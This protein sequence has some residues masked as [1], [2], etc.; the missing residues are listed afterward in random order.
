M[1]G[2]LAQ[3]DSNF[4]CSCFVGDVA[5]QSS[6][7]ACTVL[8]ARHRG[9]QVLCLLGFA[10]LTILL[11]GA[12]VSAQTPNDWAW[13]G[14]SENAPCPDCGV[15]GVY[16]TQGTSSPANIPGGRS[17]AASWTDS[18]GNLWLFGGFGADANGTIGYLNDLWEYSTTAQ[19][20]TWIGG[21][22]TLG[23]NCTL[24]W[25]GVISC[26]QSGVYGEKN[27]AA[28]GNSPGGR[29]LPVTWTDGNG[30]LWLF[31]GLGF[32]STGTSGLLNDL[33]MFNP[34]TDEWTWVSGS[35]V[36]GASGGQAGT[37]GTLGVQGLNN[38]PGGRLGT[39][40]W[41]DLKGNLWLFGGFGYSAATG[42][43]S[44][45]LNDL[46]EFNPSTLEWTWISGSNA[47][48]QSGAY[49]TLGSAGVGNVPGARYQ[50]VSWR[51][52]SGNLWMF[53][54]NGV[55]AN[56]TV[57]F[58][59][60]LWVFDIAASVWTWT[61]GNNIVNQGPLA[62]GLQDDGPLFTPGSRSA[63]AG[64]VDLDNNL[65]VMGG[66]GYINGPNGP[67]FGSL[68]DLWT[69]D[70]GGCPC[71]PQYP[72]YEWDYMSG[73]LYWQDSGPVAASGVYG[74][75]GVAAAANTPGGRQ[76]A[77]SWT[78]NKGNFWMFGG[79]GYGSNTVQGYLN[80]SWQYSAYVTQAITF[81]YANSTVTY[82]VS[83]INLS[84]TASSGLPVL[85]SV[86]SG[87]AT[88]S[89]STV[90]ITGVGT[91]VVAANQAGNS[92]F[93]AAPQIT[94]TITVIAAPL[95]VVADNL[96]RLNNTVNPTLT[97]SFTGL[98]NGDTASGAVQGS[99]M[100]STTALPGSATGTYPITLA[101]G[102]L[103][104]ANYALTAT[105]GT[106]TITS[107]GPVPDYSIT[108]NPASLTIVAG[109]TAQTTLTLSPVNYFAGT[110]TMNCGDLPSHMSCSF[111]PASFAADGSGTTGTIV[112]TVNTNDSSADSVL[113]VRA[114]DKQVLT[115]SLLWLP[116]G[117]A[118]VWAAFWRRRFQVLLR[119]IVGAIVL[120]AGCIVFTVSGCGSKGS[121]T[122]SSYTQPGTYSV[123]A[124]ASGTA[125]NGSG[126]DPHILNV[127]ITVTQ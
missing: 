50:S 26:G 65:W 1:R 22:S 125:A 13:M 97:Y 86:L 36:V 114:G 91:V 11:S 28:T 92:I 52:Q 9:K 74:S 72:G 17:Q 89:G 70:K 118:G 115:A 75:L 25:A 47:N 45:N 105:G 29:S 8:Q 64:W 46:W 66:A 104:A 21:A 84:A 123:S 82:G 63:A 14:G 117:L 35:S 3:T 4:G 48:N 107:G 81:P 122:N 119:N 10:V 23:T 103:R 124:N 6:L 80:D 27:V 88:I 2:K 42:S 39:A 59:N 24:Q 12:N 112:L 109:Q 71:S 51:D 53:G 68:N 111:N 76:S 120:L 38:I 108:A 15:S 106:L 69:T 7:L 98:V 58:L 56:G 96:T 99:P 41:I 54:G 34:S 49:G 20:W 43:P 30:N 121:N 32:D 33:W 116:A 100:L 18:S 78:D 67:A 93:P 60:D 79:Y 90:T 126:A 102:T 40:G 44:S 19:Q 83:P 77:T 57:G 95:T 61:R 16:G 31:S 87:P 37:Y 73:T 94:R 113:P 55:D 85:F 110:L 62:T 127:S 101:L 5:S